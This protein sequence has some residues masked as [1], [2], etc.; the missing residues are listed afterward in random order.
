MRDLWN[1]PFREKYIRLWVCE[2]GRCRVGLHV[3]GNPVADVPIV[4]HPLQTISVDKI[5]TSTV[6]TVH[7]LGAERRSDERGKNNS[8]SGSDSAR[9]RD[10]HDEKTHVGTLGKCTRGER[11][12]QARS[13]CQRWAGDA[14]ETCQ[15]KRPP[16][17]CLGLAGLGQTQG[18][19]GVGVGATHEQFLRSSKHAVNLEY[20]VTLLF[21]RSKSVQIQFFEKNILCI[22]IHLFRAKLRLSGLHEH[23]KRTAG[24]PLGRGQDGP[25]PRSRRRSFTHLA[26]RTLSVSVSCGQRIG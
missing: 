8:S 23:A 15:S 3:L 4:G 25:Q 19:V 14:P 7:R 12:L 13:R 1:I 17:R 26:P 18:Q 20:A 11:G 16:V 9:G 10:A 6:D 5:A 21:R 24:V 2:Y 22:R